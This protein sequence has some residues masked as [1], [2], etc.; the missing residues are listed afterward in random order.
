VALGRIIDPA[1]L[2]ALSGHFYPAILLYADWPSGAA[3]FHSGLAD[4]T[5]DGHTWQPVGPFGQIDVPAEADGLAGGAA[6]LEWLGDVASIVEML[7]DN[8]QGR[9]VQMWL[10]A[11]TEPRGSVLIG[12]PVEWHFGYFDDQNVP[13][14]KAGD[15][16]QPR[17]VF[18]IASGVPGR[19]G[20][21][22]AH[23][24]EDHE[25]QHPGDTLLRHVINAGRR[26]RNPMP[27][28]EL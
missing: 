20:A 18:G 8:P 28:P 16:V 27:W 14:E 15:S 5:W 9:A 3:R 13:M 7:E 1:T 19:A 23:S 24:A 6:T 25:R 21:S 26:A 17:L 4:M 10:A 11:V 12:E 2:T 22:F